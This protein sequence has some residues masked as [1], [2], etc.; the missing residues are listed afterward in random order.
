M[1]KGLACVDVGQVHLNRWQ[2]RPSNGI[3]QGDTG[4]RIGPGVDQDAIGPGCCH[5]D[6]IYQLTLVIG[7]QDLQLDASFL[8]P[9]KELFIDLGQRG[10]PIHPRLSLAKQVQVWAV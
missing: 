10:R 7:L 4:V 9:R 5:V 6:R 1:S 8:R 2:S 3:P